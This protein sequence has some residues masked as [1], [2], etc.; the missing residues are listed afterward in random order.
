MAAIAVR[1][2]CGAAAAAQQ[3]TLL[4]LRLQDQGVVAIGC[5]VRHVGGLP[6]AAQTMCLTG[7]DQADF[8]KDV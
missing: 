7:F 6:A 4:A 3:Q 5:S 8:G 1:Q 2:A